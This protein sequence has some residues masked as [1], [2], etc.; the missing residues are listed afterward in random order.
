M[1]L[2]EFISNYGSFA[3]LLSLILGAFFV[4]YYRRRDVSDAIDKE[5]VDSQS[6]LLNTLRIEN[7]YLKGEN[8]TKDEKINSMQKQLES[9]A[10]DFQRQIDE[11]KKQ[12]ETL[13]EINSGRAEISTL[14]ETLNKFV[15]L[16]ADIKFFKDSHLKT[17]KKLDLIEKKLGIREKP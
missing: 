8:K 1:T 4:F 12:I 14:S 3:G 5:N 9:Q 11:M 16:L 2:P 10:A 15:P 17:I 7:E 6:K 13:K